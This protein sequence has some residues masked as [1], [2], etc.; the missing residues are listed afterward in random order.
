MPI[1]SPAQTGNDL[2]KTIKLPAPTAWPVILAFGMTLIFSGLLTTPAVSFLGMVLAVIGGAG[3]FSDVL[4][5]EKYE[6]IQVLEPA[7]PVTT[8]RPAVARVEWITHELHRARLPLAIYPVSAG[9]KG[10]L[11]GSVAMAV[12]AMAYGLI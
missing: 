5:L 12:L 7:P 4:P 1:E 11:A 9:V 6:V 10:G 2:G 3:W 8:R